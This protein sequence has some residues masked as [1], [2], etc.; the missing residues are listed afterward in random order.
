MTRVYVH[1]SKMED[2][3][4][5]LLGSG[6]REPMIISSA[7]LLRDPILFYQTASRMVADWP[8]AAA[9]NLTNS[10]KNHQSWIGQAACLYAHGSTMDET[11]FAWQSLQPHEKDAANSVADK[12]ASE[13]R[14]KL[15]GRCQKL[16]WE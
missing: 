14:N 15:E 3:S 11:I 13:Y 8:N 4:A 10:D 1:Y 16:L 5:G 12:V 2:L 9:H 6:V 7:Q